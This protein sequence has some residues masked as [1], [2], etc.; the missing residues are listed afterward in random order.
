MVTTNRPER[1]SFDFRKSPPCGH[2]YKPERDGRPSI[3][4]FTIGTYAELKASEKE[5]GGRANC[6][7][8][9]RLYMDHIEKKLETANDD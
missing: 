3:A 7:W 4:G 5:L 1:V 6:E 8:C 2:P 9:V